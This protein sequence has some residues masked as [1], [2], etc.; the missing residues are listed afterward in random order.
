MQAPASEN[1]LESCTAA[2]GDRVQT[3]QRLQP[4][5]AGRIRVGEERWVGN[6]PFFH[7]REL[8][9]S[10]GPAGRRRTFVGHGPLWG[11]E[12]DA[13]GTSE[14]PWSLQ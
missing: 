11:G 8:R 12:R 5:P 2:V 10:T 9:A 13:R 14:V 4:F 3:D 6:A 1:A 7:S